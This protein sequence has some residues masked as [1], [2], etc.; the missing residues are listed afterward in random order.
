MRVP[1]GN[2]VAWIG[3]GWELFTHGA[4][5]LDRHVAGLVRADD[6]GGELDAPW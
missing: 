5:R 2:A 4:R 1:V 3:R 6:R